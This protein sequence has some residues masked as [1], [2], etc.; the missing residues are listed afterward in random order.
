LPHFAVVS[1]VKKV[2]NAAQTAVNASPT[3]AK[4]GTSATR[5]LDT[6]DE[7]RLEIAKKTA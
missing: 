1:F 5:K 6:A 3:A 7:W 4:R 2:A